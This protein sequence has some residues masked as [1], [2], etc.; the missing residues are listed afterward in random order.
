VPT[1][2]V[3][4]ACFIASTGATWNDGREHCVRTGFEQEEEKKGKGKNIHTGVLLSPY[5]D[6]RD[7]QA[8][9]TKTDKLYQDIWLKT[10]IYCSCLYVI[11]VDIVL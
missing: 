5:P 9:A 7:K 10:G 6:P 2:R 8:T 1:R 3:L 4:F 11:S